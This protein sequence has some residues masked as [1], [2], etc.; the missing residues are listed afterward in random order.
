MHYEMN[1]EFDRTWA[2]PFK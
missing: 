1:S 2:Y